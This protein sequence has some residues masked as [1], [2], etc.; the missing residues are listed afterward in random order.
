MTKEEVK[1]W[2]ERAFTIDKKIQALDELEKQCRERATGL[3]RNGQYNDTGKSDTRLNGT[4]NALIRLADLEHKYD[5]QKQELLKVSEEIS[6]AIALLHDDELETVLIYRY[7]LFY[8]IEKTAKIMH[9]CE[10]TIKV[11]QNK[12]I[13]K[14]CSILN[15]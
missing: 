8:T 12:A 1:L 10:D 14:L 7:L 5:K 11:R 13:E 2:L 3:A 9:Y 4:E 6:D 15:Q